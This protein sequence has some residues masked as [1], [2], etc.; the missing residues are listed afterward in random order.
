[1]YLTMH[2]MFY[3]VFPILQLFQCSTFPLKHPNS[4]FHIFVTKSLKIKSALKYISVRKI[5]LEI[6]L[7]HFYKNNYFKKYEWMMLHF[8]TTRCQFTPDLWSKTFQYS[9]MSHGVR[10]SKTEG[11]FKT[12]SWLNRWS[13]RRHAW[14]NKCCWRLCVIRP[15][16]D[17]IVKSC[18]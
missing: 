18:M 4:H 1:M 7:H 10:C 16:R 15:R 12:W 14:P 3:W 5:N 13:A 9:Q 11:V 2:M 8:M 17:W 6:V